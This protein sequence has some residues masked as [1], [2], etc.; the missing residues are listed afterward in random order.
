[1]TAEIKALRVPSLWL[2][3][4]RQPTPR[5]RRMVFFSPKH[6]LAFLSPPSLLLLFS[7]TVHRWEL[8]SAWFVEETRGNSVL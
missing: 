5:S 6:C 3:T 8:A 2:K 4:N 7:F 1:M